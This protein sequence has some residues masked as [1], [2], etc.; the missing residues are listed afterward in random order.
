M[1]WILFTFIYILMPNTKVNLASGLLGGV[2]AGTIYQLVQIIYIQFQVGVG[3]A[4]VVYGSFAALPLFLLWLQISWRIV[5]F[6]TEVSF[7]HQNVDTYEFEHDC[8]N[9]SPSFKRLLALHIASTLVKRFADAQ[10]PLTASQISDALDIPIRLVQDILFELT[11]VGIIAEVNDPTYKQSSYQPA[12][13]TNQ[14]TVHLVIDVLD[15]KGA[16]DIPVVKTAGLVKLEK[17]LQVFEDQ[18]KNSSLNVLLKNI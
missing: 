4:N 1:V 12:R 6:G 15:K 10:A 14:L 16:S 5:L 17:T 2:V 18:V 8:L 11:Q 9:V 7:A 13:D 3:S